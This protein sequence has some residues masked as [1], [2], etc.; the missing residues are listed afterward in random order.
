V[1]SVQNAFL[2][3]IAWMVAP[4]WVACAWLVIAG[5]ATWSGIAYILA[6]GVVLAGL[7]TLPQEGAPPKR[8]RGLSRFGLCAIAIVAV[9]RMVSVAQGRTMRFT[10]NGDGS[11]R[12]VDRLIDE[13]DLALAG[14]SA[15]YATGF[16][17]DDADRLPEAM[18]RGYA[19]MRREEGD[20][21]TPQVATLLGLERASAFDLIVVDAAP[22]VRGAVVFLHGSA[23][24]FELPCFQIARVMR[25]RGI[26]TACPATSWS[27]W[28]ATPG[29][30]TIVRR[31][32]EVV[33]A[34]GASR[35]ILMGLSNGGIS[36]SILAPR[37]N[38]SIAGLVLF[39]G[40]D[41]DAPEAGVPTLVFHGVHDGHVDVEDSRL[42]AARTNA[43]FIPLPAGHF[44]M[45]VE[46][47]RIEPELIAFVEDVL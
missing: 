22:P 3:V 14:M 45:L 11:G 35:V 44:A 32:L 33:R 8:R 24:N 23:G 47:E 36:G 15:A 2:R 20:L 41:S 38:G 40:A 21:P 12:L 43:R 4:F 46:A 25:P 39:S 1:K 27:G 34:R 31:S 17:R 28:W 18:R 6:A 26:T 37:L 10:E 19:T 13:S 42:Y 16:L 30:E 7:A 29:G 9:V 5:G